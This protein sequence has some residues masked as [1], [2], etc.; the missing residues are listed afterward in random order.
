M[1]RGQAL[2]RIRR[3]FFKAIEGVLADDVDEK[4]GWPF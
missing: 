3:K 4:F 1:P 2:E